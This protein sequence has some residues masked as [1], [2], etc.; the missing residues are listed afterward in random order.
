MT[1]KLLVTALLLSA[2][3]PAADNSPP[4]L[5]LSERIGQYVEVRGRYDGPGKFGDYITVGDEHIYLTE[6][7]Q[8]VR[9]SDRG[10]TVVAKGKLEY[11]AP[12]QD[13]KVPDY[14]P[15]P[16]PHYFIRAAQL[17]VAP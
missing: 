1:R 5:L 16:V 11:Y 2:C 6:P 9:R 8:A 14:I 15:I 3:Q 7:V 13:K 10:I 12:P 17:E 4:P